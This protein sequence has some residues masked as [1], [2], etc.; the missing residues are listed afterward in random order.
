LPWKRAKLGRAMW[1]L[2]FVFMAAIAVGG[3]AWAMQTGR[4]L[5]GPMGMFLGAWV[6]MG[7][8]VDLMQRTGRG[9]NRL[10]RLFRLPGADWGKAT[11]HAGLGVTMV[12]IAGIY[13]WTVE[14]IRVA[15]IDVP[16]E[17]HGYE[18]TLRNVSSSNGPNYVS[19]K[20]MIDVMQ[21]G[22]FVASLEPE[23]R[24]YPVAQMPTTEA[25]IHQNYK[26]DLYLVIG[27]QQDSGGWAV[28]TYIKSMTNWIW[29][30]CAMMALGGVFSLLDRRFRVAVGARKIRE[31]VPAE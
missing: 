9:P 20:A 22:K 30:G 24:Y 13:A 8:V 26:R 10:G 25:A 18:M 15:Q 12:G 28:R 6:I 21:D 16:F 11:A 29:I 3:L 19:T 31:G 7:V 2:R 5:T 1:P 17:V 14:D 27:D 23:K 4:S